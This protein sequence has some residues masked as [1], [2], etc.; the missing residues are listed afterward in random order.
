MDTA[1]GK[2]EIIEVFLY[3]FTARN[4]SK[5]RHS[6]DVYVHH[7]AGPRKAP[8]SWPTGDHGPSAALR[9]R[10][11]VDGQISNRRLHDR[12]ETLIR[13]VSG[14]ISPVTDQDATSAIRRQNDD[15]D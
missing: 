10:Y 12:L 15:W 4:N 1:T 14:I 5:T 8:A 7:S 3:A 13:H 11:V 6:M 2:I 9:Q